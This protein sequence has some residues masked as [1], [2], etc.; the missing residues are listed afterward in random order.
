VAKCCDIQALTA[1]NEAIKRIPGIFQ[2]ANITMTVKDFHCI[3]QWFKGAVQLNINF[4][5]FGEKN[6]LE[7]ITQDKDGR[8]LN[9]FELRAK[10]RALKGGGN[11]NL[12]E[13]QTWEDVYFPEYT[14]TNADPR[15]RPKYGNLNYLAHRLGDLESTNYGKSYFVLK[16]S[17]RCNCTISSDDTCNTD[18]DDKVK[19]G[20]T[21]SIAHVLVDVFDHIDDSVQLKRFV[22]TLH[23]LSIGC[24]DTEIDEKEANNLRNHLE[25]VMMEVQV[26]SDIR[27]RSDVT[28]VVLC[29]ADVEKLSD[30]NNEKIVCAFRQRFNLEVCQITKGGQ[31]VP[32]GIGVA[33]EPV[34]KK[35][36]R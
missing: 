18:G 15:H 29:E 3:C 1:S 7:A 14:A 32:I 22:E 36:K 11:N 16:P 24:L 4:T 23:A 34:A 28:M 33:T 17:V 9:L 26:H 27:F 25:I 30:G 5:A 8:Y 21:E 35:Q 6:T 19:I 31:V 2:R 10:D 12:L 13:R 20:T